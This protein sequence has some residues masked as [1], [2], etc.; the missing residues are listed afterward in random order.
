MTDRWT[1][2]RSHPHREQSVA[3]TRAQQP[4]P[5]V[6]KGQMV[7]DSEAGFVRADRLAPGMFQRAYHY[8][9]C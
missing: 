4:L 1:S 7:W 8:I 9:S 5:T 3:S 6:R 2:I